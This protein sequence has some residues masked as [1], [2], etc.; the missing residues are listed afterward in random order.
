MQNMQAIAQD[1]DVIVAD[2]GGT[3]S[4]LELEIDFLKSV[5]VRTLLIKQSKSKLSAQM[6]MAFAYAMLQNYEG[7]ITIDGN[8]QD[9]PTAIYAFI[10]GLEQGCDRIQ[11]SRFIKGAKAINSPW[12]RYLAIRLIHAPLI[13]ISAGFRYTDSTNLFCA[14]SRRLLLDPRVAPFRNIFSAYE[15]PD[16]LAIRAVELGY[17]IKEL[18]VTRRYQNK[19]L[20]L[21]KV[22][23]ILYK[24]AP[25]KASRMKS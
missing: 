8:N 15:L 22:I 14:Y 12:Y 7:I 10:Q 16:Y 21:S 3:D 9:D 6:R 23:P 19:A 25:N 1:I 17:L 5:S 18:P 20:T 11:G 2:S 13:S 4:F 24:A